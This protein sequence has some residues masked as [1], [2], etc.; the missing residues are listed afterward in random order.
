MAT[1][2]GSSASQ[3]NAGG[4]SAFRTIILILLPVLSVVG[5]F[6]TWVLGGANGTFNGIKHE[7][8]SRSAVLPGSSDSLLRTYTG[9]SALDSQLQI[10]VTFFAPVVNGV[11]RELSLFSIMGFGQFGAVWTLLVLESF[12]AGNKARA[13]SFIGTVGIIFQNIAFTVTIP[14][15]LALHLLTSPVAKSRANSVLLVPS[16]DLKILPLSITLGYIIPSLLMVLPSHSI[17]SAESHQQFIAFW[18]AFPL[19]TAVIHSTARY[20][21]TKSDDSAKRPLASLGTSYLDGAKSVYLF[22]MVFCT[23]TFIPVLLITL[24]PASVFESAFNSSPIFSATF[25]GVFVPYYP[26][27]SHKVPDLAG[28]VLTFLQWDL[29]VGSTAVVL[30]TV[31]LY[32]NA[33]IGKTSIASIVWKVFTWTLVSGP[34]GAV[35]MLLWERDSIVGQKS[36]Q[37]E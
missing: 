17:V 15:Y 30:W 25:D 35:T 24:L 29:Y 20:I 8:A 11:N 2:S 12:R 27:L 13:V 21:M 36:K 18:Q 37:G 19:W 22:T 1:T 34:M 3:H 5:A 16:L 23:V 32:R 7:L 26:I 9:V 31:L 33:S 28:G 4:Y 14:L 10:L 6:G